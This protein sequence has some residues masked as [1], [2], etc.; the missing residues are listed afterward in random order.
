MN[1][2][3]F[4]D[5]DPLMLRIISDKLKKRPL[6][7]ASSLKECQ[8]FLEAG[9][10]PDWV[11]CDFFLK[12]GET[13]LEVAKLVREFNLPNVRFICITADTSVKEVETSKGIFEAVIEKATPQFFEFIDNLR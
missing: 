4:V 13:A 3:L 10:K 1:S 11:I 5:D 7:T 12:D 6:F 9:H 8:A 2:I